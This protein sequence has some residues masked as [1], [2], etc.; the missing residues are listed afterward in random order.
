MMRGILT[1]LT[2]LSALFFPWPA[3]AL[4]ALVTALFEPLVPLAVGVFVDTLYYAG[5]MPLCT[6]Y[7]LFATAIAFLVQSR[8]KASI[9]GR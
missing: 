9:I 6:L 7:G 5:G 4:L 8:I 1:V 3:T 2:F